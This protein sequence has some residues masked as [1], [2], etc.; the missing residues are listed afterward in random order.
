MRMKI[1]VIG[2]GRVGSTIAYTILQNEN[3]KLDKIILNDI[4]K[5]VD[6]IRLDLCHAFPEKKTKII[7][8]SYEELSI[9]DILIITAGVPRTKDIK[10]RMDLLPKNLNVFK[11]IFRELKLKKDAILIIITNPSDV[12][13]Y[14]AYKLSGLDENRVI[15]FGGQLDTA[16]LKFLLS[17]ELNVDSEEIET[18]V[19]GQHGK[20]M[21]PVFSQTKINKKPVEEF[22]IDKKYII[23]ELRTA[24]E[25]IIQLV[26]GTEYGPGQHV[27]K[28]VQ[29]ISND[30]ECVLCV[31]TFLRNKYDVSDVCM[32]VPC[33]I[34]RKGVKKTIELALNK[35]ETMEFISLS[36]DLKKVLKKLKQ[37][38]L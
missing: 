38:K 18:Y 21:I 30:E 6:G 24:S 35:Y 4:V 29:A 7:V 26:G 1:G 33:I 32:T 22:S 34:G 2:V 27:S 36:K 17:N 15:G 28:L 31:S 14:V 25:K 19:I 16:R 12:L 37:N 20:G 23:E 11:G 13:T 3:I 8:G 5:R 10:T 9:C